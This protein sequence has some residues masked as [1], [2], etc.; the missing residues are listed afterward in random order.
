[1]SGPPRGTAPGACTH[2]TSCLLCGAAALELAVPY[3]PTPIAD[4]YLRSA[5]ASLAQPR[6]ALDLWLCGACG[7]LQLADVVDPR[8]LFSDYVYETS[9]SPG[10]VAHF[11]AYAKDMSK[12][13]RLAPGAL[14]VE[15]GS[16]DGSLLRAFR[17]GGQRVLGVDPASAIAEKATRSGVETLPAF[18][19]SGL[20]RE[21]KARLG[22]AALVAANNVFAHSDTLPDMADGIRHLLAPD[23]LF[24]FEVSYLPDILERRLFDTVYH[25]HLCYHAVRPLQRFLRLHGL[26]LVDFQRIPTKGGSFRGIAQLEGGPRAVL[27]SVEVQVALERAAGLERLAPYQALAA[28]LQATGRDLRRAL[29]GLREEGHRLAGFGASATVTTLLHYF[30]L[31]DLL[32]FLVDDNPRKH[33]TYAPGSALPVLPSEALLERRPGAVVVLAW[34]YADRIVARQERYRAGG[35]RFVIPF[36]DVRLI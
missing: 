7:H 33:G 35:G 34:T 11:E 27:T 29:E 19:T 16:N 14:V 3:P 30:G 23:G 9:V 10:L 32:D 6:F 13:A 28:S 12:N 18:F 2:R 24:T 25:E 4:A 15:I 8:I 22:P 1:M 21:I 36:P 5:E 26:E 31:H 17:D 20:A